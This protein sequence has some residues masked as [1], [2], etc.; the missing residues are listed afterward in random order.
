MDKIAS[1]WDAGKA[2]WAKEAQEPKHYQDNNDEF[3]HEIPLGL[4][5]GRARSKFD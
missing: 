2:C 3:E 1:A 4:E 5:I